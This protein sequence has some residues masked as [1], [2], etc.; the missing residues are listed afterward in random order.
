MVSAQVL[1]ELSKRDQKKRRVFSRYL[2]DMHGVLSE[3]FRVLKPGRCAIVV[4]GS[5]TMRGVD[6]KTHQ[7][8][9]E[10]AHS[11]GFDMVGVA[12]RQL[13]RDKRMMPMRR[14]NLPKSQIEK[15]MSEEFV[16][17]M[18]KP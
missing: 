6:V 14:S 4:V 3:M 13:D 17:G 18:V 5:S 1:D 7:C 2:R 12:L 10:I 16:I 15:R 9:I 11:V 8:L